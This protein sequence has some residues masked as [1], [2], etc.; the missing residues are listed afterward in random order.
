[1]LV[2]IH[3]IK[4]AMWP[5][6]FHAMESDE[7]KASLYKATA[8]AAMNL[9]IDRVPYISGQYASEFHIKSCVPG[10]EGTLSRCIEIKGRT[11]NGYHFHGSFYVFTRV[12]LSAPHE[13]PVEKVCMKMHGFDTESNPCKPGYF[14]WYPRAAGARYA[15]VNEEAYNGAIQT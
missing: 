10:P 8:V 9:F 15:T 2:L 13:V 4:M 14:E 5:C 1:M 7:M 11:C 12:T 3:A 6:S